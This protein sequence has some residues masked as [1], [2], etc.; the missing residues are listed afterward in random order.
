MKGTKIIEVILRGLP[1]TFLLLSMSFSFAMLLGIILAIFSI[2]RKASH[3]RI[4]HLYLGIVRGTP[5]LLML[6]LA[7]Y[8]LPPLLK[9]VGINIDYWDKI[10]FGVLGLSIGWSGYLAEA[11]RSA[12]LSVD[13]GQVEAGESVGMTYQQ[14]FIHFI[15][16]QA[17][18]IALPNI[19]N[20]LIGLFKATSLV[21]VIGVYDM[22]NQAT[23]LSN[24]SSGVYQLQIF[25][26][27]AFLYWGIVLIIEWLFRIIQQR[28]WFL[29]VRR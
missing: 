21:Y 10:I 6:L 23:N 24:Q 1:E 8:G 11:F 28:Y 9:V 27:L 16:P 12:Y 25:I 19:E 26:V 2:R 17:A 3:H 20:L 18:L 22:Y 4:I 15:F 5:P 7:Y 29:N 13:P 14:I